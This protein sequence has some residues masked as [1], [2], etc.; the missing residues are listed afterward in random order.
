MKNRP[1]VDNPDIIAFALADLS[2]AGRF[3]DIEEVFVK[4]FEL[5]PE[6]FGWRTQPIPNYKALSKALRDFENQ[7]PDLTMRTADGLARQLTAEG[8]EWVNRNTPRYRFL[9]DSPNANPPTRRPSQRVLNEIQ[10]HPVVRRFLESG[11]DISISKFE[12][13]DLLLCTPDSPFG[14]WRERLETYR[15]AATDSARGD[16]VDFLDRLAETHPE[17]FGAET[18]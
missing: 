16:I 3:V 4:A 13:A 9:A 17:W 18:A 6:R 8:V 12:A 11:G 5:A 10:R 1:K 7:H 15:S 14:V 2:G